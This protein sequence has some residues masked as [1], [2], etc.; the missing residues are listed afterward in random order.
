MPIKGG[1]GEVLGTLGTYF[2]EQG[3]PTTEELKSI[4]LL[5]AAAGL[6]MARKDNRV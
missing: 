4:G 6:V 5:A 3:S 1:D 2:R